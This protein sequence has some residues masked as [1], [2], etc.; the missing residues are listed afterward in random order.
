MGEN[1][2]TLAPIEELDYFDSQSVDL[3]RQVTPLEAWNLIMSTPRPAMQLAFAIR[4]RVSSLFGVR[5]IGG[6][7][8][9]RQETVK[10]GEKLDFFTVETAS[11]TCLSLTERDRHLDVM[12]C[13]STAGNRLSITSSVITHNWFGDAYMA[14]VG[15]AHKIIVRNMLSQ[16]RRSVREDGSNAPS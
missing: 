2:E 1:I 5:Q 12:T 7:S 13:I 14:P 16:L 9:K 11:D 15:P 4:D 3:S 10:V 8:G 6:F